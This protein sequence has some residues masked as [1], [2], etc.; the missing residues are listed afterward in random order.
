MIEL[1]KDAV[2]LRPVRMREKQND[3]VFYS[4]TTFPDGPWSGCELTLRRCQ[5]FGYL[6]DDKSGIMVDVLD[7]DGDIIQE[8]HLTKQ[9]F[10]YL[11]RT[12][13]FVVEL[14]EK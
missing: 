6:K 8:F 2:A 12:L 3:F 13:K 11:R 1:H 10:Q 9:G 14:K 5:S 7:K 4:A